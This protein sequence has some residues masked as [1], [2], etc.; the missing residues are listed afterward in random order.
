MFSK[1]SQMLNKIL[2]TMIIIRANRKVVMIGEKQIHHD[3][4]IMPVIL[5]KTKIIVE[6]TITNEA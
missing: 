2:A 6:P 4:F 3:H 5:N 1:R